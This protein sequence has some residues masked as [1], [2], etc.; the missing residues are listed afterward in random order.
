MRYLIPIVL[1]NQIKK[2]LYA[3]HKSSKTSL[4]S[5]SEMIWMI[6]IPVL[7]GPSSKNCWKIVVAQDAV[8]FNN[9]HPLNKI[10]YLLSLFKGVFLYKNR[11]K[12]QRNLHTS[13]NLRRKSTCG[14]LRH[15]WAPQDD[16]VR[17]RRQSRRRPGFSILPIHADHK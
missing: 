6:P 5:W 4:I 10:I 12:T 3:E 13:V 14:C 2:K 7:Y 15:E 1:K 8:I 9:L 17:R 16:I 11:G